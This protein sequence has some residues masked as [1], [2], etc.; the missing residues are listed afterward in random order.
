VIIAML[1]RPGTI[2]AEG[3]TLTHRAPMCEICHA[4]VCAGHP[5]QPLVVVD[6]ATGKPVM[7]VKSIAR[8]ADRMVY[9]LRNGPHF[10]KRHPEPEAPHHAD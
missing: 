7:L 2:E 5:D 1:H 3:I 9:E 8:A 4:L 10:C 6:A